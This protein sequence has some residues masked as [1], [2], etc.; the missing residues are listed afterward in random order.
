METQSRRAE[1]RGE[2]RD[3]RSRSGEVEIMSVS[4]VWHNTCAQYAGGL[5]AGFP[6][7]YSPEVGETAG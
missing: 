6:D 2:R 7:L 1:Q 5:L 4:D 3:A